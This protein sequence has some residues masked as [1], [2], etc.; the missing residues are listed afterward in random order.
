MQWRLIT[1]GVLS[2]AVVYGASVSPAV[3]DD[4]I[5]I[6]SRGLDGFLVDE[7]DQALREALHMLDD[8]LAELPEEL[9]DQQ[10]P[11][12][13]LQMAAQMLLSPMTIRM[14]VLE[15]PQ[16]QGPPIYLALSVEAPVEGTA[17]GQAEAL[18]E[19]LAQG[20]GGAAAQ[21]VPDQPGLHVI[22]ADGVPL[23]IGSGRA[24]GKPAF[25][26][27]VNTDVIEEPDLS[28]L[29]L[30]DGV[31]PAFYLSFD[32]E[33]IQPLVQMLM[34]QAPPMQRGLIEQQL[35]M[36][37]LTG[38]TPIKVRMAAGHGDDLSHVVVHLDNYLNNPSFAG[39]IVREPLSKA[40]LDMVP[41]DATYAQLGK[42]RLSS[43]ADMM[44]AMIASI[45]EEERQG[46]EDPWAMIEGHLGIHPRRD[47]LDHLGDTF[48]AYMSDSTGGGGL[49]SMV[50]FASV[51]DEEA[52][53]ATFGKLRESFNQ[54]AAQHAR[55]YVQ[56]R[57][58]TLA[59]HNVVTLSFPGIPIP[60]EI[61][62]ALENGYL[63]VAATP[64]AL[65]GALNHVREKGRGLTSNERFASV[66]GD[67]LEE[68]TYVEFMDTPRLIAGG[69]GLTSLLLSAVSNGLQSPRGGRD[70]GVLL[71]SYPEL[72]EG[73]QPYALVGYIEGETIVYHGK[74]DRSVLV[75]LAGTIG[76][77]GGS[78][79]IVVAALGAGIL[80]PA[81]TQAREAAQAVRSGTQLSQ[82]HRAVITYAHVNDD[83]TPSSKAD[84]VDGGF[85][86]S[87]EL[88]LSPLGDRSEFWLDFPAMPTFDSN[89]IVGYDRA[90]YMQ[91]REVSVLF[92]DGH[93]EML[94]AW[95]FVAR[96]GDEW[97]SGVDFELPW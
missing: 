15:E 10:M 39:M 71:P 24:G 26:A 23:Y 75:N 49:F 31:E 9:Q 72:M 19:V 61:S 2:A 29:P 43:I 47:L 73:A 69:Y 53:R 65:I 32:G 89:R 21:E 1:C 63:T 94:Q 55:G 95:D 3:A 84:L 33:Q 81:V 97:N 96:T 80:L 82:I 45:P 87:E 11:G 22:D 92:A 78:A 52:L 93:V 18:L 83:A 27:A 74:S 35:A 88:F 42:A 60:L 13:L 34:E 17:R 70:V 90:A 76:S 7:K 37:G 56:L 41:A 50:A 48:G 30:P 6:H 40:A 46:M 25:I 91:G 77:I 68:A 28:D 85:V 4:A 67:Q 86:V 14:G 64:Q 54:Q 57:E 16:G 51:T 62:Y 38:E 20:M 44:D 8:R 36:S 5:V 59:G 58:R 79:P 12:A 66:A